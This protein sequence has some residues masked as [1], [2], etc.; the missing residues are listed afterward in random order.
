[1]T[2]QEDRIRY[3][4]NFKMISEKLNRLL[5]INVFITVMTTTILIAGSLFGLMYTDLQQFK[6]VSN[7]RY[8]E[9][10]IEVIKELGDI[11]TLIERSNREEHK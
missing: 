5:P 9:Q 2:E 11:K 4:D 7:E 1:M 3:E 10:K 8:T 6:R